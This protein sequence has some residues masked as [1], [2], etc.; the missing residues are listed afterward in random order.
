MLAWTHVEVAEWVITLS[1]QNDVTLQA[2]AKIITD[3]EIDGA[4]LSSFTE[5]NIKSILKIQD[6]LCV[7]RI[8]G[9]IKKIMSERPLEKVVKK[10]ID[11]TPTENKDAII[12]TDIL[13]HIFNSSCAAGTI[14]EIDGN[15][16]AS[17]RAEFKSPL[18]AVQRLQGYTDQQVKLG[19]VFFTTG[20]LFKFAPKWAISDQGSPPEKS[21]RWMFGS[22]LSALFRWGSCVCSIKVG[23]SGP[24]LPH[25]SFLNYVHV[26]LEICNRHNISVA[27]AYDISV[28]EVC[29]ERMS[30]KIPEFSLDNFLGYQQKEFLEAAVNTV[31]STKER[32]SK[33]GTTSAPPAKSQQKAR[34]QK[35]FQNVPNDGT[36]RFFKFNGWC[37]RDACPFSHVSLNQP[38]LSYGPMTDRDHRYDDRF[39]PYRK[40]ERVSPPRG[41]GSKGKGHK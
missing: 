34:V 35:N 16:F 32:D 36:C 31:K 38:D 29:H 24:L 10:N 23:D 39:D 11:P 21:F 6:P 40:S 5:L 1:S 7:C 17:I 26:L 27:V 18:E 41:K 13:S 19:N 28:R 22:W 8:Q 20:S 12:G 3:N 37:G 14:S 30:W 4:T 25:S 15:I 2:A 33:A 9:G